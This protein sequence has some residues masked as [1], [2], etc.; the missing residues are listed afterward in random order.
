MLKTAASPE[1][2]TSEI[3]D[4]NKSSDSVGDVKIAKKFGKS[5]GQKTFKSQKLA[6]SQKLSKLG[7]S[8]GE[9][10]I[11][12]SNSGNSS[13]FDAKKSG[14][15]IL[16]PKARLAFNRLRLAFTKAVILWYFDPEYHIWIKTD[17]LGYAIGG[18]LS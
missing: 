5:K 12:L 11:K 17:A 6:K 8:K 18:V 3:V 13:N 16:T 7:K 1:R 4:D 14:P 10:L 2:S 15:S 9:K